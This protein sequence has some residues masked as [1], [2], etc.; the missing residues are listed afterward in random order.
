M[1]RIRSIKPEFWTSEQVMEC[2]PLARL[3]FIGIWN[4]CDDGGNHPASEK[5]IKAQVFPGDDIDSTTIRLLL[6]ELSK[7]GLLSFYD[8]SGRTYLH[9]NGWHHQKIDKKTFKFPRFPGAENPESPEKSQGR[10]SAPVKP[11]ASGDAVDNQSE[12]S[13]VEVVEGSSSGS[14]AF[15]PG[16]DVDVDVDTERR[17]EEQVVANAPS[18]AQGE[19]TADKKSK[20]GTRLPEDW[21]IP[22]DWL[23]WAKSERTELDDRMLKDM[24]DSFRDYW[25]SKSGA[26]ATKRD[27]EATWRNWVRNQRIGNQRAS[28]GTAQSNYTDLDKID[29][30]EGLVRQPDGT[31][32]VAKP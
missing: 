17:G 18:P 11:G 23:A 10:K 9:V 12:S 26:N 30:T 6:E 27:W 7:N 24:A 15:T 32:R 4:F 8:D 13:G 16:E 5:T 28:P 21:A 1:A 22:G 3:L 29:H 25:V 20:R 19:S 31:Y 14:R 2:Q